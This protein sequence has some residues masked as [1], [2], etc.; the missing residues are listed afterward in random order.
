MTDI[1]IQEAG[2]YPGT[3]YINSFFTDLPTDLRFT[4]TL[5]QQIVPHTAVNSN[6]KNLTFI[7]DRLDAPYV[8]VV[9]DILMQCTVIITKEDGV[10]LPA[11]ENYVAPIN[12]S[13]SSL[14]GTLQMKINDDIISTQYDNY[15]YRCYLQ[16]LLTFDANAKFC[17]LLPSGWQDDQESDGKIE[18]DD[19]NTG[20]IERNKWFRT[21][22]DENQEYR[23]G[24]ATF[25]GVF[26]H[27]LSG[28]YKPMPPSEYQI[29]V[30]YQKNFHF[31]LYIGVPNFLDNYILGFQNF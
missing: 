2:T 11:K 8:Y 7:L 24:G 27:T 9:S 10:S 21:N 25:L 14:F 17:Q 6:S 13:M 12:N 28:C 3:N 5:Y 26:K 31:Q 29:K 30:V 22:Y 15:P 16:N 20:F 18:P 19:G 1:T 23:P 4:K